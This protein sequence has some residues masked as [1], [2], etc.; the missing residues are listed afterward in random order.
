MDIWIGL[1]FDEHQ[2]TSG[3]KIYTTESVARVILPYFE[4]TEFTGRDVI[5]RYYLWD[6]T[7]LEHKLHE[8][9]FPCRMFP[10]LL[11]GRY[12]KIAYWAFPQY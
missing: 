5:L 7:N 10:D 3:A 4:N 11:S 2:S 12:L 9:I 6:S 1:M 8:L